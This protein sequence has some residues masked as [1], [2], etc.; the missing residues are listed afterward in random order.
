MI[1]PKMSRMLAALAVAA[2]L[3]VPSMAAAAFV[4]V[5]SNDFETEVGLGWTFASGSGLIATSPSPVFEKFLGTDATYGISNNTATLT[6]TGLTPHT[7][8]RVTFDLYII[9]SWDGNSTANGPDYWQLQQGATSLISTTFSNVG[10]SLQSFPD[11]YLA[12]NLPRTGAAA[13]NALG[14]GGSFGDSTYQLI[15]TFA[16]SGDVALHF[17]ASGLQ[18][19]ADESWGLDNVKVEVNAIP[20]PSTLLLLGSGLGLLGALRRRF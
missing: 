15:Y 19:I 18:A 1:P 2:L 9:Q 8:V 6:L 17:S 16:H 13:I 11:N 7:Q 4:E 12:D 14:Y 3:L 20:L 5:Y 10:G